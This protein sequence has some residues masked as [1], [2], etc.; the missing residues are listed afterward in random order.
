LSKISYYPN[1]WVIIKLSS[2]SIVLLDS[3]GLVHGPVDVQCRRISILQK[4]FQMLKI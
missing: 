1:Q 2:P 3:G 4:Y